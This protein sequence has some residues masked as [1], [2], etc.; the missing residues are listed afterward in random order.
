MA[1]SGTTGAAGAPRDG[2]IVLGANVR[3]LGAW[4]SGWRYPGAHRDPH[5]DPAVLR[6]VAEVAEAA[7]IDFLFFGDWLATSPDF[8][9]TD[10][11]L[12][13]RLEPLAAVSYLAG[14]TSRI[15]LVATVN[16]SHAEPY[17]VAR[18]S[19]S[20]DLLSGGRVGLNIAT[21]AELRSAHNFG[22]EAVHSDADRFAAAD[23][24]VDILR[25]LWD[26]WDDGSFVADAESGRLIDADRL[27]AVNYV[28]EHR[29]SIGPLNVVRPPQGHL[30]LAVAGG[31]ARA[32]VLA[33]READIALVSP[34]TLSEAV[35][36]YAETKERAEA[37]GRDPRAHLV[38]T[39]VLPI[40]AETRERA[41]EIYDAL[42]ALVRVEG[43]GEPD[44]G[45]PANRTLRTLASVL[46]VPVAAVDLDDAV[47]QR[48]VAR[49]SDL[50]RALADVVLVRSG[51]RVGGDRPLTY[52]HLLVA[53]AVT[54]PVLV[55]SATD[56]ADHLETWY[57]SH[58]VDGF[59]ILSAFLGG[60]DDQFA[61]F[62]RLVI[63][64][65]RARGLFREGYEHTTL[66][67]NLGLPVAP[68]VFRTLQ[69]QAP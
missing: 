6:S 45:L 8:E 40:V 37:A 64:E 59:T 48:V 57:R 34:H 4:P 46:G 7:G 14:L 10:P 27:H 47:P 30:P 38:V 22:W 44:A 13:A 65:L 49:F 9:L 15:G 11:Y 36:S 26:S 29:A 58:A 68:S 2:H 69:S 17:T 3:T 20:A 28:G 1:D 23:E 12:L 41:W 56:I 31:S 43:R 61:A 18:A 51:R 25:G 42:V 53:H 66:R 63:P 24:F 21:G 67:G 54:A 62:A 60:D 16:S 19:A 50:G 55:G 52:R 5:Q 39:P 35:D 32:R 33:A